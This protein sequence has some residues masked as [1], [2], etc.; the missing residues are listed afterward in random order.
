[1]RVALWR[2][3]HV[4]IDAAPPVLEDEIGLALVAPEEGWRQRGDMHPQGTRG[5]RASIVARARFIEDLVDTVAGQGVTQYVILGAGLDTFAQRRPEIASKLQVF[6]VDRPGPQVWKRRRLEE[7]GLGVA[8]WLHL[9]S[10]DFE[11]GGSWWE[12]LVQAGFDPARAA[13]VAVTGVT[14]YLTRDANLGM[15]RQVAMLARGSVLAMTFI[16]PLD[17]VDPAERAQHEAVYAAARASGTP[18]LSLLSPEEM[19]AMARQAGFRQ[20]QHVATT[21]LY[22]RYFA[23]RN[24]GLRPVSGESFLLAST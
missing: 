24:D 16:P 5:Y 7:L 3:L 6:E 23:D 12:R 10:V 22:Q 17:L 4:Q 2:A 21:D 8:P 13:V 20:V 15:L 14:M 1:V 11:G 9:V 19:L 18:F